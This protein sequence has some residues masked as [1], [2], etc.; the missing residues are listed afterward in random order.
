MEHLSYK[1]LTPSTKILARVHSVLNLH[2]ILSLPNQLLAHVPIT[3]VTDSLTH[4]LTKDEKDSEDAMSDVQ[5]E[6]EAD[7]SDEEA[8]GD[9]PELHQLFT[10]GQYVL[11]TLTQSYPSES[12][13]RAFLTLY[14]PSEVVRLAS[15][16]EMSLVP[17]KVNK[18]VSKLDVVKGYR[19][20]GEVRGEE[21]HGWI[22]GLGVEGIEGFLRKEDV[23]GESSWR[24]GFPVSSRLQVADTGLTTGE[25]VRTLSWGSCWIRSSPRCKV[26][27]GSLG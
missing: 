8:D 9:V 23:K 3:E 11:T 27:V 12:S 17:G 13:N 14:P 21:D 26:T 22:V 25:Q 10:P 16:L 7:E 6:A 19:V 15:R 1:R 4:L 18:D 24:V 20:T 2:L 5:A